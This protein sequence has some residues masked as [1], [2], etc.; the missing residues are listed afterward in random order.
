MLVILSPGFPK[1]EDDSTCLPPIQQFVL[2]II[3]T[4]PAEKLVIISFQYPFE[5][6][7][8]I[9]NGV[10][11][12]ALGGQNRKYIF[13]IY[14]WTKALVKLNAIHKSTPIA[15]I[16]SLWIGE[17][18]LV[19]KM[20]SRFRKIKH[21]MW[22][23]GQ[24]AKKN[25]KY[26]AFIKPKNEQVIAISDFNK[27]ELQN[28]HAVQ[29][30]V[31]AENG[32]NAACFPFFNTSLRSIDII[33]V[34]SLIAL[35]NY[36]QFIQIVYELKKSSAH[37]HAVLVGGGPEESE[38]KQMATKLNLQENIKFTGVLPHKEV[39]QLM[40][41]SKVF[42]HPSD[43]EGNST[44]MMEALF[45]GCKVVAKQSLRNSSMK[46]FY[47]I[48]EMD[49]MLQTIEELLSKNEKAESV[50]FNSMDNTAKKVLALFD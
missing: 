18:A 37:I 43:Y 16:L 20:F 47:K 29:A 9:W 24:D 44:V 3:K 39:L 12:I 11:V 17:C 5:S 14:T 15:G 26:M 23:H 31:I 30:F 33:G 21:F 8:Y 22:S 28:N 34:G 41:N 36:K 7:K 35:K 2:S 25:N 13:K 4:Q 6:K 32:I 42:L 48:Q 27:G 50:L 19:G 49:P 40:N 45:A 10:Q 38:L 1:D 46:N